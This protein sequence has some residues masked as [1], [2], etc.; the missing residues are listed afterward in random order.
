MELKEFINK[1]EKSNINNDNYYYNIKL[2]FI[3]GINVINHRES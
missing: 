3:K 1:R 2:K